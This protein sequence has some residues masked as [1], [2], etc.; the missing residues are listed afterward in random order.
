MASTG[1]LSV[2]IT[3]DASGVKRE[4][5]DVSRKL[6]KTSRQLNQNERSWQSW[7]IRSVAATVALG[8]AISA[9]SRK[10]V[11]YADAFQSITNKLKIA[12]GS[13]EELTSVTSDLFDMANENRASIETTVDLY[14]KMER[15]T[16]ELGFSSE[17]LLGI[18]DL[19]G[20]AFVIGGATSKE[21][22][23]AIRQL[24][25][26]LSL[27]ALRGEEFNSVAEQAPVI[28][29]AMKIATGKNAGELRKL[30]ATGAI[31]S[32]ILI[33][34]IDLYKDKILGDYA[35]TQ[36]TYSGK[37]EIARNKAIEF[38]GANESIKKVVSEAG[39]AIVYLSE[40]LDSLIT[41]VQIAAS[42]YG[43][44]LVASV[45]KS[46][47]AKIQLIASSTAA[48]A[49]SKAEAIAQLQLLEVQ[50]ALAIA[51]L[52]EA[53]AKRASTTAAAA[54]AAGTKTQEAANL[55]LLRSI[56]AVIIAENALAGTSAKVVAANTAIATSTIATTGALG[57]ATVA[58][59]AFWMAIGGW[60][61]VAAAAIYVGYKFATMES[62]IEME[63]RAA[64]TGIDGFKESV[65]NM[66]LE[67]R[68]N[69]QAGALTYQK[70]LNT[71]IDK[72][73]TVMNGLV[74]AL[75]KKQ[76]SGG[77]ATQEEA[78]AI[79]AVS[80]SI[81]NLR[82]RYDL[83]VESAKKFYSAD[84]AK[85]WQKQKQILIDLDAAN[86]LA[87]QKKIVAAYEK[88]A[89]DQI[90]IIND[91]ATKAKTAYEGVATAEIAAINASK[92]SGDEKVAQVIAREAQLTADLVALEAD[93]VNQIGEIQDKATSKAQVDIDKVEKIK[94]QN[95]KIIASVQERFMTEEELENQRYTNELEQFY[96]AAGGKEAAIRNHYQT[97]QDMKLEHEDIMTEIRE[98]SGG[99]EGTG[100][101]ENML[102]RQATELEFE[103]MHYVNRQAALAE[104]IRLRKLSKTEAWELEQRLLK[105]HE[106]NNTKIIN[107][108]NE[109]KRRIFTR[110]AGAVLGAI[111]VLGKKSIKVQK[112]VSLASAAIAI[113]TGIARAQELGFP[114]NIAEIARVVAVG[115]SAI[116]GIKSAKVAKPSS[117][118]SSSGSSTSSRSYS[119]AS[120]RGAQATSSR[121]VSINMVGGGMFSADQVRELIGQIN[122]QV[123]DGVSLTTGG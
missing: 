118:G 60:V 61:T 29:E 109:A 43:S 101:I 82:K 21:M 23:G 112:A 69:I 67:Q 107:A 76:K 66:T 8:M 78:N 4:L 108:E 73:Q 36:A 96:A 121:N 44:T 99:E 2:K 1:D 38:V 25:Q 113:S 81:N 56:E 93:R 80:D 91:A 122:E 106:A 42:L 34:S 18:T 19:V 104:D 94:E 63:A 31:T 102:E 3:A 115:A 45:S 52:K 37:M 33:Q 28:M 48:M 13:T 110:N 111:S 100:Y 20:K 79:A 120:S 12:T 7:S 24:G 49:A 117:G 116:Q 86:E 85:Q 70:K 59:N 46:I 77:V 95:A 65:K 58:A 64:K 72:Q 35:K 10:T 105:E 83:S 17:R 68:K 22:D 57:A 15:S 39:D 32:Q 98:D 5:K 53:K 119:S 103:A 55:A 88:K 114:A 90:T 51:E 14:T 9:V 11:E 50:Q 41:G 54:K 6:N 89:R 74:A 71:E 47:A 62:E 27:G 16:R 30:A 92:I 84:D 26:S 40:N 123:G 87:I 75:D 97:L